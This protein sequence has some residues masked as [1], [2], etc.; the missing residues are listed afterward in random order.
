MVCRGSFVF[1]IDSERFLSQNFQIAA[2]YRKIVFFAAN[3]ITYCNHLIIS[4]RETF[5]Y[6]FH[7]K[8]HYCAPNL[9]VIDAL[10]SKLYYLL[11]IK[12]FCSILQQPDIFFKKETCLNLVHM[13]IYSY[14]PS[15]EAINALVPKKY[16]LLQI[17]HFAAFCSNFIIFWKGDL[18]ESTLHHKLPPCTNFGTNQCTSS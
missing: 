14:V 9:K 3:A 18:S 16:H 5:L 10:V 11:Q 6:L 12:L 4:W 15:L 17:M 8:N 2:K 7:M 1:W 13:T